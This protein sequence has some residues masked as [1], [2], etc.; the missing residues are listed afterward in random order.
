MK[1]T[2]KDTWAI[3][4]STVI[5]TSTQPLAGLARKIDAYLLALLLVVY[6]LAAFQPGL[7]MM[8]R[9]QEVFHCPLTV[10]M[11]SGMLFLAGLG[12]EAKEVRQAMRSWRHVLGGCVLLVAAPWGIVAILNTWPALFPAGILAGLG[13]VALMP[14][15]ASSVAWTQLSRGNVAINVALILLSTIFAPAMLGGIAQQSHFILGEAGTSILEIGM[16]IVPAVLVGALVRHLVGA[17]RIQFIRP[18]LKVGSAS[19]LL[20]LNYANASAALPRIVG[21]FQPMILLVLVLTVWGMC[22]TVFLASWYLT[23]WLG[24]GEAEARSLVFGIGMKN[25]G[26]ALVLAGLWLE[27]YPLAL[28][29]IIIYTFSQHLFA[30]GYHQWTVR[31]DSVA[32]T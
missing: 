9:S 24:V 15:A 14:S 12:I 25:T 16:W 18:M 30:A 6:A 21:D 23:R 29:A 20:L 22:G 26:M 3:N 31:F 17:A 13:L 27:Q 19:I 32:K 5:S 4:S 1:Y 11:L 7:G 2:S 8:I 28:V 10:L